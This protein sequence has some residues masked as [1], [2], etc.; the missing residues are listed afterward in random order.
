MSK[1]KKFDQ[2]WNEKYFHTTGSWGPLYQIYKT[3][4][5]RG[6]DLNRINVFCGCLLFGDRATFL[7]RATK[8][9]R[10]RNRQPSKD[11]APLRLNEALALEAEI[12]TQMV[13]AKKALQ[14]TKQKFME[15]MRRVGGNSPL[16]PALEEFNIPDTLQFGKGRKGDDWGSF[17]LLAVT[18]HMKTACGKPCYRL[19]DRLL[20]I[21]RTH[22][23][24]YFPKNGNI[25]SDGKCRAA[26]RIAQLKKL[27]PAWV[28]ALNQIESKLE[29]NH[30]AP[31]G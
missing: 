2:W 19:A 10:K 7:A 11:T 16:Y 28:S 25:L 21:V 22:S 14:E 27:H 1:T 5:E 24:L 20:R 31:K 3:F 17:F 12:Q 18:E 26:I 6:A 29:K 15:E 9:P 8:G 30:P 13:E 4:H 23:P